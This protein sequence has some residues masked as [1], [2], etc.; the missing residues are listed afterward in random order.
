ML[1]EGNWF[2]WFG[3]DIRELFVMV[4][5]FKGGEYGCLNEDN[6]CYFECDLDVFWLLSYY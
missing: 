2:V 5:F 3:G 1:L 6:W 4:V